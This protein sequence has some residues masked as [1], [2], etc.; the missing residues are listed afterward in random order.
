MVGQKQRSGKAAAGPA[1]GAAA[2]T[3]TG[4]RSARRSGLAA[5]VIAA[6]VTLA[7]GNASTDIFAGL[8]AKQSIRD[9]P[10]IRTLWPLSS[11]MS[12][13]LLADTLAADEGSK[14]GAVVR[15]PILSLSFAL[16]YAATGMEP[17]AFQLVNIVIHWVNAVLL[18]GLVGR[19]IGRV[20]R[21]IPPPDRERIA[22]AVACLWSVHPL[23]TE[24]VTYIVQRGESLATMFMLLVLY[25]SERALDGGRDRRRWTLVAVAASALGMG[26]KEVV[27]VLPVLVWLY[28]AVFVSG[29]LTGALRAH[30]W[31][32]GGLACTWAVLGWLV[33]ST[34]IDVRRDFA[35]DRNLAYFLSQPGVIL[36][37]LRLALWPDELHLYVNTAA[38]WARGARD[39]AGPAIAVVGLLAVTALGLLRRAWWG[40]LGA[41]CFVVLA[42]TSTFV[43]T[44]DVL[45]EHRTYFPLAAVVTLA[46]GLATTAASRIA[47]RSTLR[48]A[49]GVVVALV[50]LAAV[51]QTRDRNGAY[52]GEFSMVYPPDLPEAYKILASH[53]IGSHTVTRAEQEALEMMS[54]LEPDARERPYAELVLGVAA[55]R[56]GAHAEAVER[57]R[58]ALEAE[59]NFPYAHRTLAD[60]LMFLGDEDEALEHY[61][62]AT[63]IGRRTADS[64]TELGRVYLQLEDLPRARAVFE[65][66]LSISP[67]HGM[68]RNNLG[69]V[70]E[71]EGDAEAAERA[72]R[73]AAAL[74]PRLVLP[75]RNLGRLQERAGRTGEALATLRR[76]YAIPPHDPQA[77]LD[78]ARVLEAAGKSD[79]AVGVLSHLA[80]RGNAT[81]QVAAALGALHERRGDVAAAETAYQQAL[82]IGPFHAGASRALATLYARDGRIEEAEALFRRLLLKLPNDAEARSNL[83]VL[84][85]REGKTD[86]ARSYLE[87]ALD[88]APNLAFANYNLGL[89][90]EG[91]GQA[92]VARRHYVRELRAAPDNAAAHRRIAEIDARAGRESDARHHRDEAARI[93]GRDGDE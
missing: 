7:Y 40:Y 2:K 69:V 77:G 11:A 87:E 53:Y 63:R 73:E 23:T 42:P 78:L 14:G 30:R 52:R 13:P 1:A 86:E 19:A 85:A 34:F 59:P 92:D 32:H 70:A 41:L 79:E 16:N 57:Y 83:G 58:N 48:R 22:L 66:A 6:A 25:A 8:D 89:L 20:H 9:N 45:Q 91:A 37:Y 72:Y 43:A 46:V 27:V 76:A 24:A 49:G 12:L 60:L 80:P 54:A 93:E 62:E 4:E 26:T 67:A 68:A 47:S 56:R 36:H 31:L 71:R 55:E 82:S 5:L 38:F 88:L 21:G 50:V 75:L 44:S 81:P 18:F 74:D 35:E 15:R 29:S 10:Y 64:L 51:A 33:V 17:R 90:Y 65:E 3:H 39:I 61:E 84:L 28:D